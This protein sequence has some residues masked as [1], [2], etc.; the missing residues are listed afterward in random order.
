AA[1]S[2]AVTPVATQVEAMISVPFGAASHHLRV[3]RILEHPAVGPV[4]DRLAIHGR[5]VDHALAEHAMRVVVV[6]HDAVHAPGVGGHATLESA[7]DAGIREASDRDIP[8]YDVLNIALGLNSIDS[9]GNVASVERDV[10]NTL[11]AG[12]RRIS[13][14]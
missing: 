5:E 12:D 11:L 7:V 2:G 6:E 14:I 9:G 8:K 3:R 10:Q 4:A 1:R 13:A